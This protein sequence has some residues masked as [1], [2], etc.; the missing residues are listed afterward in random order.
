MM[1]E[2]S[3]RGKIPFVTLECSG[4]EIEVWLDPEIFVLLVIGIGFSWLCC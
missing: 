3:R 2:L 4:K 1:E